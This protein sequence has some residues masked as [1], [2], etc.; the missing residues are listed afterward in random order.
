MDNIASVSGEEAVAYAQ[1]LYDQGKT[2]GFYGNYRYGA[3]EEKG[4][5]LYVFLDCTRELSGFKNFLQ[6][7]AVV[8]ALG[9]WGFFAIRKA[10]KKDGEQA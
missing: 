6:I 4:G 2:A 3:V 7:S 1:A 10:L 5:R 8:A 9:V